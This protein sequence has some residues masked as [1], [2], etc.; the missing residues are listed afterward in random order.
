[1]AHCATPGYSKSL[2]RPLVSE[3][4][5]ERVTAPAPIGERAGLRRIERMPGLVGLF[6]KKGQ[7]FAES[8]LQRMVGSLKHETFYR[9]GTWMD[10]ARGIYAGWILRDD[11]SPQELPLE[12]KQ[13]NKLLLFSGEEYSGPLLHASKASSNG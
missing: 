10:E 6:T 9:T 5:R 2:L 11:A 7:R 1:M 4:T 13:T 3:R 8:E 12:D